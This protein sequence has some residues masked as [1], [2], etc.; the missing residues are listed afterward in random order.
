MLYLI[1]G[2]N[3]NCSLE[4]VKAYTFYR[5]YGDISASR[6]IA[7]SDYDNDGDQDVYVGREY[8]YN[9]F[10]ENQTLT[11]SSGDVSYHSN[12]EPFFIEKPFHLALLILK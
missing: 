11:G 4:F 5:P 1:E 3:S 2:F 7:I 12:P 8:G 9:W 10:F 6:V